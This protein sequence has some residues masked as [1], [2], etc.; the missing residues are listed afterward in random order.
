MKKVLLTCGA[1][2]S[3]GFLAQKMRQAT[4]VK[5]WE[6]QIK[7]VSESEL[8]DYMDSYQ[9]LLVGPH[10]RYKLDNLRQEA[11]PYGL[12][13]HLIDEEIYGKLDG[14]RMLEEVDAI[15]S[16]DAPAVGETTAVEK[17]ESPAETKAPEVAVETGAAAGESGNRAATGRSPRPARGPEP[18]A[19]FPPRPRPPAGSS[20]IPACPRI[21]PPAPARPAAPAGR[22][23]FRGRFQ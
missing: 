22:R 17:S 23:R 19:G 6:Y 21:R 3:S 15:L 20:S 4:K 2:A 8:T 12:R 14:E 10:L 18:R 13:V 7:A 1:G 9:I 11:S 5:G 16:S